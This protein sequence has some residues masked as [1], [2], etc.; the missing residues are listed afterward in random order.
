MRAPEG[1]VRRPLEKSDPATE[2]L[3]KRDAAL[4]TQPVLRRGPEPSFCW[5]TTYP[6][7]FHHEAANKWRARSGT[8]PASGGRTRCSSSPKFPPQRAGERIGGADEE[9]LQESPGR[10]AWS[11]ASCGTWPGAS[12]SCRLWIRSSQTAYLST[13]VQPPPVAGRG[14]GPRSWT[15]KNWQTLLRWDNSEP[16]VTVQVNTCRLTTPGRSFWRLE[17]AGRGRPA[18]PL[19]V[20]LPGPP[21]TPVIWTQRTAWQEGMFYP[22]DPAARL[23]VLAAGLQPGEAVAGCLRRP[24]RQ[25]LCRRDVSCRIR[26]RSTPATSTPTKK[27]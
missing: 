17:R 22:Q 3:D 11:T 24:R 25:V 7:V 6:A 15:G 13:A 5:T 4:A 8:G 20:G 14:P 27:R 9:T 19:A 26:A 18:P 2:H 16:P 1:L 10:E 12:T 23:A 21:R